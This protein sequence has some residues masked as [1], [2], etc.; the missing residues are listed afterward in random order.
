MVLYF[1][2]YGQEVLDSGREASPKEPHC[3]GA[4]GMKILHCACCKIDF[5]EDF[6]AILAEGRAPRHLPL[7]LLLQGAAPYGPVAPG[8]ELGTLVSPPLIPSKLPGIAGNYVGNVGQVDFGAPF[9]GGRCS[10]HW[11][12]LRQ[13]SRR[14]WFRADL[15][16]FF[17]EYKTDVVTYR[18]LGTD[19]HAVRGPKELAFVLKNDEL[20]PKPTVVTERLK[21]WFGGGVAAA[22]DAEQHRRQRELLNPSECM[23]QGRDTSSHD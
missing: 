16:R 15:S 6:P 18:L 23:H 19:I 5:L 4:Y 21:R 2:S 22:K 12:C 8:T 20:F 13:G 7:E 14:L 1:R 3:S 10:R 17:R 11:L 9:K